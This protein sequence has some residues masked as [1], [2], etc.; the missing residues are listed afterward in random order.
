MLVQDNIFLNDFAGSGRTNANDTSGYIVIKDS[1]QDG[2]IYVGSQHITI[3]RN[4]FLNWEG[5]T[6]NNFVLVGEDGHPIH[7]AWDVL[8]ENNLLLGNSAHLMRSPFGVKG[9]RDITFRHNTVAGDMPSRAFAMRLNNEGSNPPNE[10][11]Q[12]YNNVWSDPAGTM[13]A[14]YPSDTND[15]S[16]TPLGQTLSFALDNNLYWN[17]GEDIPYDGGELINYTDDTDRVIGDPLLGDQ[18]GLVLPHWNPGAG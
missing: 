8:V 10:N 7:E 13:G 16:D 3:R 11:I 18:T 2:D 12:F 9:G 17:G 1:N 4:V 6:G 5:S 15:F 14:R